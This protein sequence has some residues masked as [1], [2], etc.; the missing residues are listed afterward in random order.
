MIE[1][2]DFILPPRGKSVPEEFD[3]LAHLEIEE[4][5][6]GDEGEEEVEDPTAAAEKAMAAPIWK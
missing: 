3:L 2:D 5:V 6:E 1:I 4:I